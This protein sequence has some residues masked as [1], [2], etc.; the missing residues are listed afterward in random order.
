M[1]DIDA[2][3]SVSVTVRE[4]EIYLRL[5]N[6][7]WSTVARLAPEHAIEIGEMLVEIGKEHSEE[8]E[9]E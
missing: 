2:G 4:G 7:P 9:A 5:Y 3:V 8:S 1:S 6:H